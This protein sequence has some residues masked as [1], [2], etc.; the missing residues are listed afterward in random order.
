MTKEPLP[1]IEEMLCPASIDLLTKTALPVWTEDEIMTRLKGNVLLAFPAGTRQ[2]NPKEFQ[3][4]WFPEKLLAAHADRVKKT[5]TFKE[6][7]R[8]D[9]QRLLDQLQDLNPRKKAVFVGVHA[10][11][12]DYQEY[13]RT[14]QGVKSPGRSYYRE[15][16]DHYL[17]EYENTRT[18]V[19]FLV[20]SDDK[21]WAEKNILIRPN[22]VWAGTNNAAKDLATLASCNHSVMSQ[23]CPKLL[24]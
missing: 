1:V 15:A 8:R 9:A 3:T 10:R 4:L 22:T 19:W 12:T 5:F 21:K 11:R 20:L 18:N 6:T 23:V 14:V 16:M 13:S 2:P 7:H 24:N 17:E